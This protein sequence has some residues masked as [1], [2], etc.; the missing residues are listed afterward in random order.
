MSVF[1]CTAAEVGTLAF[2]AQFLDVTFYRNGKTWR[3]K[4]FSQKQIAQWLLAANYKAY[5]KRY[6]DN[7]QEPVY[8]GEMQPCDLMQ[9]A[10]LARYY[11]YQVSELPGF[12]SSLEK[13]FIDNLFISAVTS[14]EQYKEASW[15]L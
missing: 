4:D 3:A 11:N 14:T 8:K 10:K 1:I 2:Y 5:N 6:R 7:Q 15:G 12:D 9:I 13:D